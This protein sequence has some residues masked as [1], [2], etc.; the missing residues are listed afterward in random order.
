MKTQLQFSGNGTETFRGASR[1]CV[2]LYYN[3]R[4]KGLLPQILYRYVTMKIP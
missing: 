2:G 3:L 4:K 1:L